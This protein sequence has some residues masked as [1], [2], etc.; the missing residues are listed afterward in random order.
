[1]T[2]RMFTTVHS[3]TLETR[4]ID[5]ILEYAY[6]PPSPPVSHPVALLRFATQSS[7]HAWHRGDHNTPL[8]PRVTSKRMAGV[9]VL[10]QGSV[11]HRNV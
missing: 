11:C 5:C 2:L 1:M 9:L 7:T 8:L 10:E 3:I 4:I 6:K